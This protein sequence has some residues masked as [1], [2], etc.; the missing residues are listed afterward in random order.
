MTAVSTACPASSP[1][2][3]RE[4]LPLFYGRVVDD[5]PAGIVLASAV[6]KGCLDVL[7]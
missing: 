6:L 7:R 2:L 4:L 3:G 5:L 1:N